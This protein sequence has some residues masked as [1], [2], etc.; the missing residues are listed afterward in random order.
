MKTKKIMLILLITALFVSSINVYALDTIERNNIYVKTILKSQEEIDKEFEQQMEDYINNLE[1]KISSNYLN[2]EMKPQDHSRYVTEFVGSTRRWFGPYRA[3]GQNYGPVSFPTYGG[4]IY[5]EEG[6]GPD[7]GV[8]VTIAGKHIGFTINVGSR[9]MD[10]VKG[11]SVNVPSYGSWYLYVNMQVEVRRYDVYKISN[12]RKTYYT[13]V[14]Q[15][16]Y[17][18][19]QLPIKQY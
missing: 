12:G 18:G 10:G 6:S 2:N 15:K 17:T 4:M 9:K 3:G 11:Y 16:A 19:L 5:W 7:V 1:S 8:G 14:S 13:T